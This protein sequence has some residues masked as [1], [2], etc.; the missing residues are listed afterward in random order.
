M[1][2]YFVEFKNKLVEHIKFEEKIL[3]PYIQKLI[4]F[5]VETSDEEIISLIESFSTKTFI[6]KHT[7]IE[8]DLVLVRKTIVSYSETKKTPLPYNIFLSQ[9][10]HFEIDLN[11]H[12]MI[13]DQIL[14]K[15]VNEIELN[16]QKNGNKKLNYSN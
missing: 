1:C 2:H 4:S 3:F 14:I 7:D 10:K 6:E 12:A 13:E 9:I 8:E 11:K 5:S 15:K 16:Y